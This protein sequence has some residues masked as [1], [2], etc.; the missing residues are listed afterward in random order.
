[1]YR[2]F[3]KKTYSCSDA[4]DFNVN[5]LSA[6]Y[7]KVTRIQNSRHANV[8]RAFWEE[9]CR[10]SFVLPRVTE[11]SIVYRKHNRNKIL[12]V[13]CCIRKSRSLPYIMF[14]KLL[15]LCAVR[16]VFCFFLANFCLVVSLICY[17]F[18]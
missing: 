7:S 5:Y 14:V 17:K 12:I 9:R 18:H 11:R 10:I 8:K 1:M 15:C 2:I 16:T 13:Q 6:C 4:V 3:K